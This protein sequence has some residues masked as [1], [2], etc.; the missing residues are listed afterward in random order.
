MNNQI[1]SLPSFNSKR[2]S[3]LPPPEKSKSIITEKTADVAKKI[4]PSEIKLPFSS[5]RKINKEIEKNEKTLVKTKKIKAINEIQGNTEVENN[6]KETSY[7]DLPDALKIHINTFLLGEL[8][9][10]SLAEK[11]QVYLVKKARIKLLQ[12]G[13]THKELGFKNWS[14]FINYFKSGIIEDKEINELLITYLNRGFPLNFFKFSSTKA[15]DAFL[16]ADMK[17]LTENKKILNN[18]EYNYFLDFYNNLGESEKTKAI[19]L[20]LKIKEITKNI[21]N[22]QTL[23]IKQSIINLLNRGDSLVETGFKSY[24]D[25]YEYLG[26]NDCKNVKNLVLGSFNSRPIITEEMIKTFA[27]AFPCIESIKLMNCLLINE[28]DKKTVSAQQAPNPSERVFKALTQFFPEI[29]SLTLDQHTINDTCAQHLVNFKQLERLEINGNSL[30][31]LY[32]LEK[33]DKL[34]VLALNGFNNDIPEGLKLSKNLRKID[35]KKLNNLTHLLFLKNFPDLEVF[36]LDLDGNDKINDFS[37]IGYLNKIEILNLSNCG[38]FNLDFLNKLNNLKTLGL[39]NCG[40][41]EIDQDL[42]GM[43]MKTFNS[44]KNLKSLKII[45]ESKEDQIDLF[46]DDMDTFPSIEKLETMN[47]SFLNE[48]KHEM[49][50]GTFFPNISHLD[51]TSGQEIYNCKF[52]ELKNLKTLI[53]DKSDISRLKFLENLNLDHLSIENCNNLSESIHIPKRIKSCK[54]G[55]HKLNMI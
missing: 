11:K 27:K 5:K 26:P 50:I 49:N 48:K 24:K 31:D 32:C 4:V 19:E 25:I 9:N 1:Q 53:L 22:I 16:G 36:S 30:K 23:P 55:L 42:Q 29:K 37:T 46:F 52:D 18:S 47:C 43:F 40:Q 2:P 12:E 51:L 7:S 14:H 28:E 35:F 20:K 41:I 3:S 21:K 15:L 39:T 17:K 34:Q 44:L 38:N 54:I 45:F 6:K 8:N 13:K 33:L 10:M